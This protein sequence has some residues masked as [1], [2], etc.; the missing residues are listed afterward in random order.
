MP[1]HGIA[2]LYS[3]N[4]GE[5]T[6]QTSVKARQKN[7]TSLKMSLYNTQNDMEHEQSKKPAFKKPGPPTE[8]QPGRG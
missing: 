5:N 8:A 6:I 1:W 3:M 7:E 2:T 4:A